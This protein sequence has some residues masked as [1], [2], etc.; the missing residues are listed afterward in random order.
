MSGDEREAT[1]AISFSPLP[2][3][4]EALDAGLGGMASLRYLTDLEGEEKR[5]DALGAAKALITWVIDRELSERELERIDSIGLIQ[6]I[7]AGADHLPFD[8]LPARVPVAVNGGGWAEPMAE[9]ILALILALAKRLPQNHAALAEGVFNQ[10]ELTRDLR[11]SIVSIIGYGGIGRACTAPLRALGA[12]IHAVT[13]SGGEPEP[14]VERVVSIEHLSEVLPEAD[15]VLLAVPLTRATRGLIG[16]AELEL[17]KADGILINVARGAIVD[18]DALYEHLKRNPGFSAGI[19]VWWQEPRRGESFT[20]R[21]P[22]LELPNVIGS[23]HNSGNTVHSAA[24]AARHAAENVARHL[25][26]ETVRHI[27]NRSEY[28]PGEQ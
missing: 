20:T 19:D 7:S 10:R 1:V 28:E 27:L 5:L 9:H 3:M 13:R 21:H 15:V 24:G 18:E 2:G 6:T 14:G 22:F 12:R 16:A 23:P 4:R 8:R 17:M 11:G 25:R 26:G